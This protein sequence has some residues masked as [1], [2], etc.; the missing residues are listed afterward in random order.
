MKLSLTLETKK[1]N[2]IQLIGYKRMI[3]SNTHDAIT[4]F[5][6]A[7]FAVRR[8]ERRSAIHSQREAAPGATNPLRRVHVIGEEASWKQW[9]RNV[10]SGYFVLVTHR[11][12]MLNTLQIHAHSKNN[13]A[14]ILN[15]IRAIN[16]FTTL[17]LSLSGVEPKC[18]GDSCFRKRQFHVATQQENIRKL[19]SLEKAR[20]KQRPHNCEASTIFVPEISFLHFTDEPP[21]RTNYKKI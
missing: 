2:I 10:V 19:C 15:K 6:I 21:A 18:A 13:Y 7:I 9:F 17:V 14:P 11:A 16:S 3:A 1:E 12:S 20:L 5:I 8:N 4:F